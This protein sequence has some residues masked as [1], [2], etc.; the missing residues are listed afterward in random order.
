MEIAEEWETQK[1]YLRMDNPNCIPSLILQKNRCLAHST[2][3]YLSPAR[4]MEAWNNRQTAREK[5]A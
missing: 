1:I 5:T 4:C 3:D 2:L